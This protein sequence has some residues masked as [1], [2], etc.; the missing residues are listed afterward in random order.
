ML[1]IALPIG[2][3][4]N[5]K[6]IITRVNPGEQA[7]QLGL[8]RGYKVTKVGTCAVSSFQDFK[9]ALATYKQAG[10]KEVAVYY[11]GNT[12]KS[13]SAKENFGIAKRVMKAERVFNGNRR[14]SKH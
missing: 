7:A 12:R 14:P 6:S 4:I 8:K 1:A 13:K 2:M 5:P 11:E 10:E 3:V 9:I